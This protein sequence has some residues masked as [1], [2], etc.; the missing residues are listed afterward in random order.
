[1]RTR[2]ER[3]GRCFAL[4]ACLHRGTHAPTRVSSQINELR[5]NFGGSVIGRDWK[6]AKI[7]QELATCCAC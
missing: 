4:G 1:M 5:E 2:R 7:A 3:T 6:T